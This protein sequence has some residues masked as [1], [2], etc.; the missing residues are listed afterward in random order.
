MLK[1]RSY[2]GDFF[3]NVRPNISANRFEIDSSF[4]HKFAGMFTQNGSNNFSFAPAA[5]TPFWR[6][7][8]T[9][10][11][12][13]SKSFLRFWQIWWHVYPKRFQQL[14]FRPCC[15][16]LFLKVRPN[17]SANRF[18]I[19]SE[20]LKKFDGMFTKRSSKRWR[21]AP[22]MQTYFW[23]TGLTW[24]FCKSILKIWRNLIACLRTGVSNSE[25][26]PLPW[27]PLFEGLT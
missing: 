22:A 20:I 9:F 19:D 15:Y 21:F 27:R 1:F 25:V 11:R 13:D 23:R 7:D 14:K 17:I 12:I 18:E 6:S 26:S 8:L 10:L 3:L 16:D 2:Y 4:F 5:T 24:N